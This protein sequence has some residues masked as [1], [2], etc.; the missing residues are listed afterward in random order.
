M[1][2][3]NVLQLLPEIVLATAAI[4]IFMGGAF[5]IGRGCGDGLP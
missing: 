3:T 1:T 5:A 4:V 2:G